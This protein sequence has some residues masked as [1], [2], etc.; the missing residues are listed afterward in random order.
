[1][2]EVSKSG[3]M[4]QSIKAF[5]SMIKHK[6][7]VGLF[8]V[9]AM[10]MKA[11]GRTIKQM[12]GEYIF[13]FQV[14]HTKE[15]GWMISNTD[16]VYKGGKTELIIKEITDSVRSTGRES[17][18]GQM[19]R[20]LKEIFTK[21]EY[22]AKVCIDGMMEDNMRGNGKIIR[23]MVKGYLNGQMVEYTKGTI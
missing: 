3:Q 18:Y 23:C 8:T 16:S 20:D 1:M 10:F 9:M 14:L 6:G 2:G 11:N 7:E 17:L 19:A 13:I 22:K 4:V 21:M 12:A 5:G 15:I